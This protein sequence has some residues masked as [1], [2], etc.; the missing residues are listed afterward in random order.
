MILAPATIV[1]VSRLVGEFVCRDN[2]NYNTIITVVKH[3][4]E[5]A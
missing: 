5:K 3:Q 2:S 1:T 4:R